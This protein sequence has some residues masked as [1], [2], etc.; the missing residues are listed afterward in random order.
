M[1]ALKLLL[2]VSEVLA[3]FVAAGTEKRPI[4]LGWPRGA[5]VARA[6]LALHQPIR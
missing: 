5:S 3:L 4:E 2:T 6:T 1:L